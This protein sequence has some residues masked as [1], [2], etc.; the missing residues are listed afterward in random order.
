MSDETINQSIQSVGTINLHI[1]A[2]RGVVR[3]RIVAQRITAFA[4]AISAI[5][6]DRGGVASMSV[7]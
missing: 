2:S 6:R 4:E 5:L 7:D 1:S 3:L